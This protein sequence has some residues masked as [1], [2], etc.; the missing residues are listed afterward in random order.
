[1]PDVNQR[2]VLKQRPKGMPGSECFE[3]TK[4]PLPALADGEVLVKTE[5]LSIDPTIRGW[6][7]RD[8]YLPAVPI[9]DVVRCAGAGTVLESKRE[10]VSKGDRLFTLVGWQEYAVLAASDRPSP[11]PPGV[12]LEDALSVFG[13]TGLTAYFGLNEIGKPKAGETLVVSGAAGGTGSIVGQLGK[14]LGLR[15]VGIAGGAKKCAWLTGE[16]GFDAAI[17]YKNENVA[18]RLRET[19][20]K[21]VDIFFDNVGGTILNDVLA[22]LA[23]RGRVVLCGA[24]SQYNDFE[25]AYGP[26]NYM[27]LLSKRGRMEGFIILDYAS[28]Y[29]EA[30][31][32]LAP[33]VAEG[34]I[35]HKTTVVDGLANAPVALRRLFTG[36]HEGKLLVRV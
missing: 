4:E 24:I 23:I 20:P 14:H 17:D 3:L 6:I 21:G 30:I 19:C 28:R 8:T 22:R 25:N 12:P 34:K 1:M 2:I 27:N 10:G 33:L 32:A 35:K 29:M 18:E 11:I 5:M 7:E 36:E 26:P 16:L 15:V 13:V 31:M 9:G